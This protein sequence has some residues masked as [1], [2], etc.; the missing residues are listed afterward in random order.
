MSKLTKA[1]M[2]TSRIIVG[3]IFIYSGFV[4]LVDPLGSTYKF[5]DYFAAMGT[6]WASSFSFT[7]AIIQSIAETVIGLALLLNMHLKYA[8]L[9][10]F[11]FM[12][13]YTPVTLV[14]ALTN[15][16]HDC[17]C[18]GDALIL[19]NW[20]TFFKNIFILIPTLFIFI[21]RKKGTTFLSNTEQWVFMG[22]FIIVSG[23]ITL[24]SYKHLPIL[25]F[26]PYKIG[27]YIPDGMIIPEG[28]PAD[29]WES[30]FIY[31]KDGVE[32]EFTVDS[33]PDA[34]WTFVDAHHTLIKKGYEP[35]IHDF[36]IISPDGTEITDI[37]LNSENY[38]F[39]FVAYKI[40]NASLVNTDKMLALAD[41]CQ[42]MG[43]P[44]YGLTASS[45]QAVN[46]FM[47][48]TGL[49]FD[50][51]NTDEIT[52]KTIIRS[53]PGLVLIKGGT[54]LNKWNINDIPD[55]DYFKTNL[56]QSSISGLKAKAD[57]YLILAIVLIMSLV[58]VIFIL[59]RKH[60]FK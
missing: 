32:K 42:Q 50:F 18:F 19:T 58:S 37:V 16:V 13:F 31:K 11:I 21:N 47:V 60:T 9:G 20:Q 48:K 24:F 4:K 22:L 1:L 26:R 7:L 23:G 45:D 14:I 49:A 29:V 6:N 17:G 46:D 28:A 27:T 2:I 10:A 40:E 36:T 54:I 38:N 35:P 5:N 59:L 39:L 56:M 12:L 43:Y 57:R 8:S 34:S 3:L 44:V 15:P 25:D 41:Y 30:K 53:N 33:L 55:L 51:Y 52:L